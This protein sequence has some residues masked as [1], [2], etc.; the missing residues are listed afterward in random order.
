MDTKCTEFLAECVRKDEPVALLLVIE[1]KGS[2]PGKTGAMMAVKN[3]DTIA[4]TIGGG[5]LEIQAI[6]SALICLAKGENKEIH[7]TLDDQNDQNDHSMHCGGDIRIFIKTFQPKSQL[8]LV[9]AGHISLELYELGIQQDFRIS[10]VDDR[11]ELVSRERFPQAQ[12]IFTDDI[13]ETLQK[14][15]ID[16]NCFITVATRSHDIDRLALEAA[17][18]SNAT[19]VGMIGSTSKIK[20]TFRYLLDQGVTK[21]KISQIYAPMGLNIASRKPKEIA[22]SILSEILLVKNEGTPEH[23]RQVKNIP[24]G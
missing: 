21:E 1:N 19:Y 23:M 17:V 15:N 14:L 7:Y 16:E 6:K 20:G 13:P 2:S 11:D 24:I 9:G 5:N 12:R 22:I 8:I 4:G 18:H 3:A 10:V